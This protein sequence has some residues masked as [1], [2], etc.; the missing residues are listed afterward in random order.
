M[1]SRKNGIVT[2][3]SDETRNAYASAIFVSD[4]NVYAVFNEE[5]DN[6]TRIPKLWRNGIITPVT[7]GTKDAFVYSVFVK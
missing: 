5:S 7:D 4:S 2:T 3:L 6:N 1:K